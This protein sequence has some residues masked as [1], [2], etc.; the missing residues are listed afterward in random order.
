MKKITKI[1][2][3]ALTALAI[4]SA[5]VSCKSKEEKIMEYQEKAEAALEEGDM[6]TYLNYCKKA[7]E[8]IGG[9]TAEAMKEA[10]DGAK[11]AAEALKALGL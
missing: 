2:T 5:F 3:V 9:E 6:E 1:V 10:A 7:A 11:E 8:L 4:S